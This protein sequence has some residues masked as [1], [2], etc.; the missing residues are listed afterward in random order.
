M[1]ASEKM[2]TYQRPKN[3]RVLVHL[4]GQLTNFGNGLVADLSNKKNLSVFCTSQN[5]AARKH[6]TSRPEWI[7]FIQEGQTD[8]LQFINLIR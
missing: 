6:Y 1:E 7:K 8:E 3:T 2:F 5:Q 4:L